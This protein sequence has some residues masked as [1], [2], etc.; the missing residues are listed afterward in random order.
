MTAD[1]APE[2][3]FRKTGLPGRAPAKTVRGGELS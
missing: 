3:A 2:N 1:G